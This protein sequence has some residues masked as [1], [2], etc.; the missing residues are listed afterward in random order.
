MKHLW[1][2]TS[3]GNALYNIMHSMFSL[4]TFNTLGGT[5][6]QPSSSYTDIKM[7][8]LEF[9]QRMAVAFLRLKLNEFPVLFGII[10]CTADPVD[11]DD[12]KNVFKVFLKIPVPPAIEL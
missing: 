4:G 6:C 10:S 3:F 9:Q 1:W 5:S 2:Q 11:I 8:L 12:H 7:P